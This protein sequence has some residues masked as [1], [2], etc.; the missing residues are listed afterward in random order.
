LS[1]SANIARI[2]AGMFCQSLLIESLC[3]ALTIFPV[4]IQKT[5]EILELETSPFSTPE[6]ALL[7]QLFVIPDSFK[8]S[9]FRS[10]VEITCD[11]SI[12]A[13]VSY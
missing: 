5:S 9:I 1:P 13:K 11:R 12:S 3:S 2:N 6:V 10:R 8:V 7:W 4:L